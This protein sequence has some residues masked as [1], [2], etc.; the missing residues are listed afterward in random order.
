M[1]DED[2]RS[3]DEKIQAMFQQSS[4]QWNDQQEQLSSTVQQ[5]RSP[6]QFRNNMMNSS[7]SFDP[8]MNMS[9][10]MMNPQFQQYQQ[11]MMMMQ[12]QFQRQQQMQRQISPAVPTIP[13]ETQRPPAGY[14]C[15]KC[16]QPGH[17]IYYC[18]S[19]TKVQQPQRI[20]GGLLPGQGGAEATGQ[21]KPNELTCRIC[22]KLMT[23]AVLVP[24]C[25]KSFCKECTYTVTRDIIFFSA[26]CMCHL[27][28]YAIVYM[29]IFA[30][31][32]SLEFEYRVEWSQKDTSDSLS[33]L[34]W[35]FNGINTMFGKEN[36]ILDESYE[37]NSVRTIS[38]S[39]R[40]AKH[41]LRQDRPKQ[42]GYCFFSIFALEWLFFY[43][44]NVISLR[45]Y[46]SFV[47]WDA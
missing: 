39:S 24:C 10:G 33:C 44:S 47:A 4:D 22:K 14:V 35:T 5:N 9:M 15:F 7:T 18:T 40:Q 38:Q 16:G 8:M 17:W 13:P 46:F 3:E 21:S 1:A 34:L 43:G 25:G 12:Q 27:L 19:P 32:I 31:A 41:A 36:K 45:T 37:K 6:Q 26:L 42:Y 28:V 20:G 23:D 11:R 2:F 30:Q 29:Y